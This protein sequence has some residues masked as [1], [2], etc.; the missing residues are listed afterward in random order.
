MKQI[1]TTGC[2]IACVAMLTMHSYE[3]V[4]E[5]LINQEGWGRRKRVFYTKANQLKKL[6]V[7][8]KLSADVKKSRSWSDIEGCSIVGVNRK[9]SYFHWVISLKDD[10]KFLIIDPETSEVY[11]GEEWA[12]IKDG[13]L[14]SVK[15]SEYIS[16][17]V[18]VTS[19]KI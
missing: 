7:K 6:L 13:Y 8:F 5:A 10:K 4:K 1:D 2:G 16:I 9:G 11:Q 18:K 3:G 14:H 15:E 12:G 17:G 19:I